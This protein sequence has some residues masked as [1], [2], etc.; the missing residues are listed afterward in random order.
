METTAQTP[1]P[2]KPAK[3]FSRKA[4][5][6]C[7]VS[8]AAA[9]QLVACGAGGDG[10]AP[11]PLAATVGG[12]AQ[13][14]RVQAV[15]AP[16]TCDS[17]VN[18]TAQLLLACMTLEG[19]RTHQAALAQVAKNH[20]GTRMAG[21]PG[22]DAS[23]AYAR[24][25]LE[26][27]GYRVTVQSFEFPRFQ[28]ESSTVQEVGLLAAQP[29]PHHVLDYSGSGDITAPVS[30][31]RAPAGC[32]AA[33]FAGFPRGHIALVR[34]GSC[35]LSDKVEHAA[36]A[37]AAGVV[38]YDHDQGELTGS[39]SSDAP[40]DIPVI[41]VSQE[42][43]Q[44]L[45][46]RTLAG[47]QLRLHTETSRQLKTTYNVF[48][49]S[50]GGDPGHVTMV[51]AHL[52]SVRA[53]GGNNDNGSGAAAVLE[54]ARLMARVQPVNQLRFALWGAEEQGLLGSTHYVANLD[55]AERAQ[56]GVYLNFDMIG[57]P[58]HVFSVYGGDGFS[59]SQVV[60]R[61]RAS[62]H[63]VDVLS[64]FY[65][66]RNIPSKRLSAGGRSD[67]K[68]FADVG[69]P[70]GG[71]FTGAEEIKSA[72]EAAIWGGRAGVAFDPCYHR[73]CDNLDNYAP[74][75]LD[76]NADAVANA[77]LFFAMNKVAG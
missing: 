25:V 61:P 28:V 7:C 76:V 29:I 44:R 45:A 47:V 60:A 36:Q 41:M 74:Q 40:R 18:D 50:V 39:L 2:R 14:L 54:T 8:A 13:D 48:A 1:I 51:G 23:V 20:N 66:D 32:E 73:A 22:Y 9:L 46:Q 65:A 37:G 33:D 75:A 12:A 26:D 38:V 11:V 10:P 5:W 31:L 17:Q 63:I 34:R 6:T 53:G 55:A 42:Q 49:Q 52:D 56:I 19:V 71:I 70:F 67:H 27:A 57:S 35:D 59:G 15:P 4:H 58:N 43:G 3:A 16:S 21:T 24:Q 72:Q 69:I 77:T 64:Q 30:S 68:P 62:A